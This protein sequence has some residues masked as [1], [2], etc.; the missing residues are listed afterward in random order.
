VEIGTGL[1]PDGVG[2]RPTTGVLKIGV[3][4]DVKVGRGVSRKADGVVEMEIVLDVAFGEVADAAHAASMSTIAI[5][6][7]RGTTWYLILTSD[8]G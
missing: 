4:I 7:L 3:A 8:P 5:M 2:R 6:W 1:E